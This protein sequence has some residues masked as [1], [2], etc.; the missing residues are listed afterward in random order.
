MGFGKSVL[1]EF[2]V[3]Y[4]I[5]KE[6]LEEMLKIALKHDLTFQELIEKFGESIMTE[7]ER[8]TAYRAQGGQLGASDITYRELKQQLGENIMTDL[9]YYL[10]YRLLREKF[11]ENVMSVLESDFGYRKLSEKEQ[12]VLMW[13]LLKL[14]A[15]HDSKTRALVREYGIETRI[16]DLLEQSV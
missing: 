8:D 15:H 10:A 2:T 3:V 9:E 14:R 4:H 13:L 11:N 12:P 7:L 6:N 5:L 1:F 16:I